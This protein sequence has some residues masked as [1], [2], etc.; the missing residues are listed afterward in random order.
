MTRTAYQNIDALIYLRENNALPIVSVLAVQFAVTVSKW[1]LR[2]RTR[3]AL[4]QLTETQLRDVGLT[5]LQARRE[6]ARLF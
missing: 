5:P 2:H 3:Q 1:T 4:G 6:A